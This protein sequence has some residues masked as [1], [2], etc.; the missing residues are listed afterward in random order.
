MIHDDD[1]F[2]QICDTHGLRE[3][4]KSSVSLVI[5][6]INAPRGVSQNTHNNQTMVQERRDISVSERSQSSGTSDRSIQSV[7]SNNSST[8]HTVDK[9]ENS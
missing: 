4:H 3:T 9:I 2:R 1:V 7:S 5:V 6:Q 8:Q